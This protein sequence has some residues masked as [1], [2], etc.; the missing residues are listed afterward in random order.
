MNFLM[1]SEDIIFKISNTIQLDPE[2]TTRQLILI[3]QGIASL[4][5]RFPSMKF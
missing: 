5:T 1:L 2:L 3:F 4:L